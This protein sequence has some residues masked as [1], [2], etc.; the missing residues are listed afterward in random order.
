MKYR[1]LHFCF[2]GISACLLGLTLWQAG[3]LYS[4]KNVISAINEIPES[5]TQHDPATTTKSHPGVMLKIANALS[6][7]GEFEAAE[8]AYAQLADQQ[9]N[10]PLGN[11]SRF[12]LAN[13]YLTR[14]LRKDLPG[15]QW[16]PLLEIAKQRYRD[17]LLDNP[18]DWDA[19]INLEH[20]LRAAPE[21]ANRGDDKGP[22]IKSVDVIVPDFTLKD[23]P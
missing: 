19:R 23:L 14:G 17:L 6:A 8:S 12:N 3:K 20:A 7:G 15:E 21:K 5:L 16:R 18:D 4:T 11:A 2:A 1:T 13:H 10:R 22:P 9:Q